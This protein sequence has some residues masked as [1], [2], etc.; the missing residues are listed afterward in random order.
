MLMMLVCVWK[1]IPQNRDSFFF[2]SSFGGK[3]RKVEFVRP[4][5]KKEGKLI[6]RIIVSRFSS[7]KD[8][9]WSHVY[10]ITP[11]SAWS[12]QTDGN[13]AM[14]TQI[15]IWSKYPIVFHPIIITVHLRYSTNNYQQH[16][17]Q[18]LILLVL[19]PEAAKTCALDLR[20]LYDGRIPLRCFQ[21]HHIS[22]QCLTELTEHLL[23]YRSA[24]IWKIWHSGLSRLTYCT[25]SKVGFLENCSCSYVEY[26]CKLVCYFPQ[27]IQCCTLYSPLDSCNWDSYLNIL[28]HVLT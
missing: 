15:W 26:I 22:E 21:K 1:I 24:I 20:F 16:H 18:W 17:H 13:A 9:F 11:K 28:L 7:V 4:L 27:A 23:Q 25:F 8:P 10:S 12:L 2:F 19:I 3:Q 5:Q 6:K 14:S